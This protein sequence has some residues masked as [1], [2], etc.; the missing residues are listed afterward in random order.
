MLTPV[1]R[2]G[3]ANFGARSN[4]QTFPAHYLSKEA[5]QLVNNKMDTHNNRRNKTS[6]Y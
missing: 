6:C 5:R 4:L 1:K 3:T 2:R